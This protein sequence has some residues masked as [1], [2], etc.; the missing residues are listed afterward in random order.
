MQELESKT[1]ISFD[2]SNIELK[3]GGRGENKH[4]GA[5]ERRPCEEKVI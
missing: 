5:K 3:M 4:L 2:E 1:Y